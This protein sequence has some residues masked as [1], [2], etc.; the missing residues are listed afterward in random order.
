MQ[1]ARSTSLLAALVLS[2]AS[3]LG[4]QTAANP[5]GHWD[6]TVQMGD[7]TVPIS[8][9][10]AKSPTGAWLGSINVPG[11]TAVDVPLTHITVADTA[12]RF[13]ALLEASPLFEARLSADATVLSGEASTAKGSVPFQLKRNGEAHVSTPPPS[14]PLSKNFEGRWDGVV[15]VGGKSL[16]V[17]LTLARAA[18]GTAVGTLLS[19]DQG[20]TEIPVTT[21]TLRDTALELELR[22][23]SGTYRGTLGAGGEIAGEWA[24]GPMHA[25]LTFTRASA[26]AKR[27]Q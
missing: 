12:V 8:V 15:E 23:I 2:L 19:L 11:S 25:P 21:V 18:D 1:L 17:A 9:D 22:G 13:N 7:Q 16:R 3:P 24:Q 27:F 5:A 4:A 20:G 26:D 10:L 6:G 14:S